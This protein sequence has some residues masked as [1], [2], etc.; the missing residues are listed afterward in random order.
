VAAGRR[1]IV[2]LRVKNTGSEGLRTDV[3]GAQ[4][5]YVAAD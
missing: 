1:I 3:T 4:I 2:R 5:R